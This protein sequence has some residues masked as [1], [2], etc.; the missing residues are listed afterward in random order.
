MCCAE[1]IRHVHHAFESACEV[2]SAKACHT[3]VGCPFEPYGGSESLERVRLAARHACGEAGASACTSNALRHGLEAAA[4][5]LALR[6]GTTYGAVVLAEGADGG[7]VS[8]A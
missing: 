1:L 8:E 2:V 4:S 3:E 5:A 7:S 6:V